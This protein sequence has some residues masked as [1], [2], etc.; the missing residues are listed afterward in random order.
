MLVTGYWAEP[1]LDRERTRVF[2]PTLDSMIGDDEQVRLVD[3]VLASVDWSAWEAEYNGHRG[4]PPIHPRYIAGAILYGVYRGIRSSRKLEEACRYRFDFVWLVEGRHIDHTTFATFRTKF[5]QP[6]KDL[7]RQIGR[8][9]MT[10]GLIRLGEV[11]FDGTR[12]KASNSRFKTLTAKTLEEKLH[13]LDE[14]FEQMMAELQANDAQQEGP[15]SPTYLP[16]SVVD[17]Q[18]RRQQ[19]QAALDQTQATDEV[20]RLRGVNPQKNPTQ[21]PITDP[22]SKVMP[23]K[24]GG[25]APNYTPVVTTDSESGFIVDC[26]VLSEVNE[27]EAAA[28]SVDRIEETFGQ[29]PEK[30]LTD[31][32]NNSG[33]VM[34]EMEEREVEFYAPV[35]SNQ[36]PEGS[37]AKRDDLTQA[38]PTSEHSRLKRNSQGQ[39]DKSCFVYMP[40]E[41]QYYCPQGHAMPLEKSKPCQRRGVNVKL[42]VYRC[43]DCASCPLAANCVS[44]R[45]K[46]GRTITRDEYEPVRER[47]A[48]RMARPQARQI[49]R[50]RPHLAETPFAILKAVMGIRQFLL[51]G[52]EKVKTE[53]LWAATAFNLEKLVR[54]MAMLRAQATQLAS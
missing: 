48:A 42:R 5:R 52:L 1:P 29:K 41:D 36:P 54:A 10:L 45:S 35:E 19:L 51:R 13:R 24:E 30:F 3:E 53:W 44:S 16:P 18:Q 31:A 28:Q 20:R 21:V 14:V 39:L 47:T 27:S 8:I 12:V 34:Q 25:Y 17:V 9:A 38:V 50:H 23:N 32:G 22:D 7:F 37:P 6:L 33:H 46:G 15:D 2:F 26:D 49:Y 11:G 43:G 4:Q 40:E